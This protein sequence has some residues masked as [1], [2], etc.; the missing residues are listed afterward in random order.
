MLLGEVKLR[1][2]KA[3]IAKIATIA[4]IYRPNQ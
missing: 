1:V 2:E 3:K 4:E